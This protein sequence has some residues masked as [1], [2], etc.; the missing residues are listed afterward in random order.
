METKNEA[1]NMEN[2]IDFIPQS[3]RPNRFI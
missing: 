2:V 1:P 3:N